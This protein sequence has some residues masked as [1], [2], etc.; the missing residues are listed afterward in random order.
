MTTDAVIAALGSSRVGEFQAVGLVSTAHFVS[1]F[2]SLV[3]PP[4]FLFLKQRWG[5]GFVELGLALTIGS[6]VSVAAQ[7]PMG[8]LADH[9]GPR[10]LLIT[11]ALPR[12][13]C[14]RLGGPRRFLRLAAAG[15]GP[16]RHRQRHLSP[17]RLRD[18]LGQDRPLAHRPSLLGPH[19]RRHARR[20]D[21]AG[22]NAGSRHHDR[23]SHRAHHSG[24][25]R[26]AGGPA[27]R[28]GARPREQAR[29]ATGESCAS[30]RGGRRAATHGILPGDPRPD[31][32][33]RPSQPVEQRDHQLFGRCPDER[34]WLA[35]LGGE[36]GAER[37]PDGE[38][39]WRAGRR[40]RRGQDAPPRPGRRRR[41]RGQRGHHPAGRHDRLRTAAC[42]SRR[43][44][45][46][47]FSP[48]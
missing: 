46:P 2:H 33:F 42:W 32:L 45:S 4:L 9:L 24:P 44:A 6:I 17:G 28:L 37:L 31:C 23:N 48:V 36:F 39:L 25:R 30:H 5:V 1:H 10:R 21:R 47:D 18:P 14:D 20:R 7:L 3:L 22:D 41:F 26:A 43:W 40:V 13:L 19:L 38:C 11:R 16:A 15:D 34:L 29:T 35:V 8:Y 12:R 27:D